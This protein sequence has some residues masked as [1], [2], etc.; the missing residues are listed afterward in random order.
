[1]NQDY[2]FASDSSVGRLPD[3]YIVADGMGGHR[4]GDYA[5]RFTVEELVRQIRISPQ[6]NLKR[7][8]D[9]S[10]HRVNTD[11]Y[12]T[13][14]M[15]EEYRGC[16][17]TVVVATIIDDVLHVANVGDSR[18]YIVNSKMNQ[19]TVDHSLVEEMV[20]AGSLDARKARTHPEKNVIT[21]AVGAESYIDIDFF[22]SDLHR[23]DLVLMCSDGLTNMLDDD[24]ILTVMNSQPT[25]QKKAEA[26]V[27]RA[28]EN[29]GLDN[30]S[31]IL[32][33]PFVQSQETEM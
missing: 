12:F 32:I 25:L 11:L 26:L 21:R 24:E 9:L 17:T 14:T 15:K 4:A 10:M 28:N 16:G 27:R 13:S 22:T 8:L 31:V 23:Q 5:S 33:D 7:M 30:I 18:L 20:L 1:M 29:G 19:L 3:L 6:R 2:I